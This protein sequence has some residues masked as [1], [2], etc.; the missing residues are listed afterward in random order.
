MSADYTELMGVHVE[1]KQTQTEK[2]THIIPWRKINWSAKCDMP[3]RKTNITISSV[4]IEQ[5]MRTDRRGQSPTMPD[6]IGLYDSEY[7]YMY[8][9]FWW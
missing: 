4:W 6:M 9:Y 2:H 7:M 1:G 3:S 5:Q 8:M